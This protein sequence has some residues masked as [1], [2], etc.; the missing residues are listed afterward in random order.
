LFE[1]DLMTNVACND[2]KKEFEDIKGAIRLEE[3]YAIFIFFSLWG[4]S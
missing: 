4:F 3:G 2:K 1:E